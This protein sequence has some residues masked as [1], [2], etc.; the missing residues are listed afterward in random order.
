MAKAGV[1]A[2]GS[3]GENAP[4]SQWLGEFS[5]GFFME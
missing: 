1:G 4:F 2:R 5:E 3:A